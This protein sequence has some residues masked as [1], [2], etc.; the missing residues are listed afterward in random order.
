MRLKLS[1]GLTFPDLYRRDGLTKLD[2]AF[3]AHLANADS[4]L[5]DRLM[6]GRVDAE[7]LS[8]KDESSLILE[9]A[10][11]LDRFMRSSAGLFGGE[12]AK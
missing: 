9:I 1:H 2:A 8:K 10:P 12:A 4:A 7:T 3:C 11:H 5:A 6:A